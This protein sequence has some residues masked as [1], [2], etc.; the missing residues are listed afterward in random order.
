MI[1]LLFII[2]ILFASCNNSNKEDQIRSLT[3]SKQEL[4][5]KQGDCFGFKDSAGKY[6]VGMIC[7]FNK[8]TDGLWEGI[9]FSNYYDSIFPSHKVLTNQKFSGARIASGTNDYDIGFDIT[10]FPDSILLNNKNELLYVDHIN[11]DSLRFYP[12][13]QDNALNL[14]G[15]INSFYFSKERRKNP[16]DSYKDI[17]KKHFRPEEYIY[18]SEAIEHNKNLR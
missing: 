2:S 12:S 13:S 7:C 1:K 3:I 18:L 9:C 11:I 14:K 17:L 5:C 6:F 10:W 8:S 16:P 15:I 4:H